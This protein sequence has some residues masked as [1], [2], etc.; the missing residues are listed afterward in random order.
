MGND[1]I[2]KL[3]GRENYDVWWFEAKSFLMLKGYWKCMDGT[4]EDTAKHQLAI[5]QL[6]LLV[7]SHNHTYI[8]DSSTGKEARDSLK[9]AFQDNGVLRRMDLLK[10]LTRLELNDCESMEDYVSKMTATQQELKSTGTEI[11]DDIVAQIMLSGLPDD[12]RPLV[13]NSWLSQMRRRN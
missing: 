7:E 12:Y 9:N 4:E 11:P 8:R 13:M 6:T 2:T 5:A 3:K 1:K 10:Y